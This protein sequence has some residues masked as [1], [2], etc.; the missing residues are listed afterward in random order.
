MPPTPPSPVGIKAMSR[1]L[2]TCRRCLAHVHALLPC[3]YAQYVVEDPD[4]HEYRVIASI[5]PEGEEGYATAHRT[6]I[7][8]QVFRLERAILTPDVTKHPFYDPYDSSI[9][10]E[11]CFSLFEEGRMIGAINLEGAGKLEVG[12]EAWD[13]IS[14]AIQGTAMC[15]VPPLPSAEEDCLVRTRRVVGRPEDGYSSHA[16]VASLARTLACGGENTLL[17][18]PFPDLLRGRAPTMVEAGQQGLSVSYCYVGVE[19]KLDLLDT[20]GLMPDPS[21]DAMSWWRTSNGRYASV[22]VDLL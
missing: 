7:I 4:D 19:R 3:E 2:D 17:V 9:Q 6:G 1:D 12:L 13:R 20:G 15:T 22:V 16:D 21:V 11:L 8:G 10:W 18:G 14:K 5:V